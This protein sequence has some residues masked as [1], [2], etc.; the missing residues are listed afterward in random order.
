MKTLLKATVISLLILL[1]PLS[2]AAHGSIYTY[3]Y[4]DGDNIITVTQNVHDTQAGAAVTYHLRLQTL[5]GGTVSFAE[6]QVEVKRGDD[7]ITQQTLS[8]IPIDDAKFVYAYPKEGN[9]TLYFIFVDNGKQIA[10]SEFPIV[11]EKG[12]DSS[13]FA[14]VISIKTFAAFLLGAGALRLYQE[15]KRLTALKRLRVFRKKK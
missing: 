4:I 1:A 2:A 5:E 9:Y 12:L 15:R 8:D 6:M 14:D 13:L 7:N 3:K 11:V 10:R